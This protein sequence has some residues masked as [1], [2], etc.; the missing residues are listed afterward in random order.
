MSARLPHNNIGEV[1]RSAYLSFLNAVRQGTAAAFEQIP[2]GGNVPLVNPLAG[3]AFDLE[4]TDSHQLAIP[5]FP[6]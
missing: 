1:D 3:V 2:L 4:G 5:P 6:R